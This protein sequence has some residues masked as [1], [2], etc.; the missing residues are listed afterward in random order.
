MT[1]CYLTPFRWSSYVAWSAKRCVRSQE[2]ARTRRGT[3]LQVAEPHAVREGD[4]RNVWRYVAAGC[5]NKL[6][7][8]QV[9]AEHRRDDNALTTSGNQARKHPQ[10]SPT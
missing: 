4:A 2:I 5:K 6:Y 3:P 9:I 10:S 8:G 7:I 1:C